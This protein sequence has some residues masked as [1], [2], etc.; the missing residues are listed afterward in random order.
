MSPHL[1]PEFIFL[2]QEAVLATGAGMK[3]A[4]EETEKVLGYHSL[5]LVN[6]PPKV[7]MDLDEKERG[8]INGLSAYLAGDYEI[9][10]IKW[11]AG[12]PQNP[13]KY[14]LPRANAF[15]ILND[16]ET[17]MPLAVMDGTYVSA[18]RT[19]AVTGVGAK[20][21][22][23][24]DSAVVAMIGNGPQA[25]TQIQALRAVLPK[26]K[27]VKAYDIV[28]EVSVSFADF[29]TKDMGLQAEVVD[30]AEKAVVEAD[31]IV[32]V[33]VADEPIVKQKW[34]KDGYYFSHVGSYQEEEDEVI[35]SVSKIV[36]DQWES[37]LHRVTPS[38]AQMY[39]KGQLPIERIY[40][41]IGDI[42]VG[43]KPGR[44]SDQENIFFSPIGMGSEDMAFAY[45]IYKMAKAQG[46]GIPLSLWS[47][48]ATYKGVK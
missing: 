5:G 2:N 12:F 43:K 17:G 21:L 8:R 35:L 46:L 48:K 20:Y 26:L 14:G 25:Y 38:L 37:V 39:L 10:G 45:R 11:I 24:K 28:R 3:E 42:I 1:K 27:T 32:T 30:S 34:L 44:E 31:V 33:T 16:C 4:L 36:V 7:V 41:D 13:R 29:V 18:M 6:L 15:I 40:C 47:G 23:R 19:G 22:A 9:G